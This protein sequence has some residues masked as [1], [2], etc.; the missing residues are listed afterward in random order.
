M[1]ELLALRNSVSPPINHLRC[2]LYLTINHFILTTSGGE[3]YQM[4]TNAFG[5]NFVDWIEPFLFSMQFVSS[6]DASYV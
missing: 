1:K 6:K 3:A 5:G 4:F 2:F